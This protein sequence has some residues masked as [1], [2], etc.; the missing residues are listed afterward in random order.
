[1]LA[2]GKGPKR[3]RVVNGPKPSGTY[4]LGAEFEIPVHFYD[5]IP[6]GLAYDGFE[7]E[8]LIGI[9]RERQSVLHSVEA[10]SM[11]DT[12]DL[13]VKTNTL[14]IKLKTL[15]TLNFGG[16]PTEQQ[17]TDDNVSHWMLR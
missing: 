8:K 11:L 1:M 12:E 17:R 4:L 10:I 16:K 15:E 3:R 5:T 2:V 14:F 13:Q 7:L 9:M 6:V